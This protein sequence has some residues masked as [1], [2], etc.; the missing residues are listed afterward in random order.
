MT[1]TSCILACDM[2]GTIIKSAC[3]FSDGNIIG[4]INMIPSNSSGS[5]EE[6]IKAWKETFDCL[7]KTVS[8]NSLDITGIGVSTPGPFYYK[9]KKSLMRHKFQSIHGINLEKEIRKTVSLPD[10]PFEFFQDA[11]CFL[12][13]EQTYGVAKGYKNCA[14][15]TLGTGLGFSVMADGK[16]LSNGRDACY[17]A[18]YRQPWKDGIIED[19]VS[20][21]GICSVYKRLS[22]SNEVIDAKTIGA[23]VKEG[24][25]AAIETYRYFGEVLGK[26][27]A[28]HLMHTY[29]EMLVIGGQISKD[30]LLFDESLITALR[31]EGWTGAVCQSLFPED[32]ALYG[33]AAMLFIL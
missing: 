29:A 6:I 15:V 1:N 23:K 30:F 3:I 22:D 18:L 21:R 12:A 31:N 28:F 9:E 25:T 8:E 26:G 27:I 20:G 11:N 32:A 19:V 33:T 10:V 7:A 4:K 24:D 13:G 17:I 2:G 16:F 14:C 5:L